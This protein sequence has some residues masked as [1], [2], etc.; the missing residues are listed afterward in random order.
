MLFFWPAW[1]L[2]WLVH[3]YPLYEDFPCTSGQSK[4]VCHSHFYYP[5]CLFRLLTVLFSVWFKLISME[6]GKIQLY[7]NRFMCPNPSDSN[8]ISFRQKSSWEEVLLWGCFPLV[9]AALTSKTFS[10]NDVQGMNIFNSL[11]S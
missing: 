5:C 8:T 10:Q 1:T 4:S 2:I 9:I 11:F 6:K 3:L 7:L